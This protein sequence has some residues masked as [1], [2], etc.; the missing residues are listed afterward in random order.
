[1]LCNRL[2]V[3]EKRHGAYY[4]LTRDDLRTFHFIKGDAEGLVNMPLQIKGLKLSISLREDTERDMIWVS[5]RSVDDFPCNLVAERFFNG[6]GHLNAAGGRLNGTMDDA[7][8]V[9]CQALSAFEDTL[10]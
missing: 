9:V 2:V 10:K 7:V 1:V 5:L 6:G 8:K 3:D 4:T